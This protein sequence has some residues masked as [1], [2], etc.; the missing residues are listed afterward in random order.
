[1]LLFIN[2]TETDMT[3]KEKFDVLYKKYY[4]YIYKIIFNV[5]KSNKHVD[6]AVQETFMK[7]WKNINVLDRDDEEGCKAFISVVA[8]NTAINKYNSDKK[9]TSK[10]V[11]ID[12]EVLLAVVNDNSV[13]PAD[14]IVNDDNVDY[15]YSKINELG[16]KY[17]D[18]MLLKY[19]YHYTPEEIS[20]LTDI[21]LK[22]VY[23]RLS[24]G[25][26]MLKAILLK[27]RG[28]TNEK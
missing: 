6:D 7:I 22:T 8:K 19:K 17:C 10:I 26:E 15:I 3:N 25:K 2:N 9:N 5:L 28:N 20:K 21:N 18:V 4:R 11:E 13:N 1:M 12:D 24:R 16:E 27:E 23:T 14:I